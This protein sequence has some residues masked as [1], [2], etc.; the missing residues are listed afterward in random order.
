MSTAPPP[1]D[2]NPWR[3]TGSRVVY[4]N[5]WISVREDAVIRPDGRDGVYGVVHMRNLALGV[6]PLFDD[7]TTVLVGQH[8]YTLD[9][10]S[11]EIP[12]GG[13]DPDRDPIEEAARELREETGLVAGRWTPLGTLHTSN[14][15]T[16]EVSL[17][18]LARDLEAGPAQPDGTERLQ[19]W[20]LP[21]SQAAAMALDGRLSDSL[22]VAGLLRAAA[23]L[24]VRPRG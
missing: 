1:P 5:A 23:L 4:A 9:A 11:W 7:G 20:R 15:V 8:R 18:Y 19:R 10:Y 21:L 2:G 12:E 3:T 22:T 14:S 24:G 16:D 6:V 13:G 17:L